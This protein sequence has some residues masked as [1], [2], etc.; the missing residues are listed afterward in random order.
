MREYLGVISFHEWQRHREK[1]Q[2]LD[3]AVRLELPDEDL[4]ERKEE[5][6]ERC[7][8]DFAGPDLRIATRLAESL[9]SMPNERAIDGCKLHN[10][11][12]CE[13]LETLIGFFFEFL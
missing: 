6:R 8:R 5:L 12:R 3:D 9:T 11:P 13:E 10:L 4:A 2:R 7:G 1:W